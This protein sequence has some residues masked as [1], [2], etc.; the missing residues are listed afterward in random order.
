MTTN[1]SRRS[2]LSRAA[3]GT[4]IAAL[5]VAACAASLTD[6][7]GELLSLKPQFDPMFE[8]WRSRRV[9]AEADRE[10][11]EAEVERK[12]GMTRAEAERLDLDTSEG[13]KRWENYKEVRRASVEG[14]PDRWPESFLD[15]FW[16]LAKKILS[17]RA[18]TREGL[19]LQVRAFMGAY[20]DLCDEY[21]EPHDLVASVC[22]FTGVPFPPYGDDAPAIHADLATTGA[23]DTQQSADPIFAVIAE[24]TE[25]AVR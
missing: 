20:D 2:I 6:G 22:A 5:P 15:Q 4:A 8:S 19:A 1:M 16:D 17:Y 24:H 11:L 23:T 7:D 12:S 9:A 21:H 25:G 3:A 18:A 14:S 10:A 13:A